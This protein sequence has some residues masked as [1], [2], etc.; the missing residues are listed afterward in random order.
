MYLKNI[1]I[2]NI[3]PISE[4]S[5]ELPF[6]SNINPKPLILVGANGAGKTIL[7][8]QIIDSFYEIA[9]ALFTNVGIN[10]GLN[11]S[12]YKISGGSNLKTNE[13]KGFSALKFVDFEN[14][15]IEYF[16]KI[17][18]VTS[19][20]I[21][22]LIN[23]FS[24]LP[25]GRE[26]NQKLITDITTITRKEKLVKEWI[27]EVHIFQPAYRYEEPFWKNIIFQETQR[28]EDKTR[29]S[30]NLDKE[31]EIISSTKVNKSYLMDLVL[32]FFNNQSNIDVA[33]WD[34]IN[35]VLRAIKKNDNIRFGIGPRGKNRVSIV[36][37][38][39]QGKA[40]KQLLPSVD[41]LSLGES[42]L[43]NLFINI[44]R[45]GDK[46]P[47]FAKEIR[48]IVA[49]DEIDV[50]L[51]TDLQNTI[52]PKLIKIFPKIQ[53]IITTHSPLFILG[54]KKEFGEDGFEIRN[55]PNGE[56][57]T[58]ER[59]SEFE[60]AYSIFKN[61][62][63]FEEEINKQ[64]L[65][66]QKPIVF[67]EGDYDIRYIKK[68]CELLGKKEILD[69]VEIHDVVGFGN[70][71][72]IWKNFD[73]KT[74]LSEIVPQKI[75]LVYDCDIKKQDKEIGKIF[76]RTIP[77]IEGSII[78]KGIENLFS[79]IVLEKAIK[80]KQEY[81]DITSEIIKTER[82]VVTKI[83]EKW[84]INKDEKGN[85]CDWI[86]ANGT[87]EDFKNFEEIFKIIEDCLEYGI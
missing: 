23:D 65:E 60:N 76:K 53:F 70:L 37:M 45:H 73:N 30:G 4:L 74:K 66:S 31:I 21:K 43:L 52:L 6:D 69:K 78:E 12:Y 68:A 10:D 71:D 63:K 55:M 40:I 46:P 35:L 80:D 19:D 86:C 44:I 82:G 27:K 67:V 57:I 38:D 11:K 85:L 26:G 62:I 29:Y 17:G 58:T 13:T 61:T 5:I 24:L 14:K 28:F 72:N 64:I 41:N 16:D 39:D 34:N 51:H 56:M 87:K 20:N 25:N 49:I 22:S 54:M 1:A 3:G 15:P 81:I 32:D 42:I 9:S 36:E 33:I 48:G 7:L 47:R 8:S 18:N 79:K 2:K 50:H 77:T 84:E 75:I 59:F 83:P